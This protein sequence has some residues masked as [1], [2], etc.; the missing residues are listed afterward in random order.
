MYRLFK[1]QNQNQLCNITF[2]FKINY[3]HQKCSD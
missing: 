2:T 1:R 3:V